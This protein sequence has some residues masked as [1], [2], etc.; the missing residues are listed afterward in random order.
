MGT[1]L[2]DG[3]EYEYSIWDD[4]II[5]DETE[6]IGF[7]VYIEEK[8]RKHFSIAHDNDS[9]NLKKENSN[10]IEYYYS[11]YALQKDASS[12]IFAVASSG[13]Y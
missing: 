5:C 12:I 8:E 3:K 7:R 11:D 10:D 4:E 13:I 6:S 1:T 2:I 9:S